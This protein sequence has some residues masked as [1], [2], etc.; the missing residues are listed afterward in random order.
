MKTD[1]FSNAW[2]VNTLNPCLVQGS[3]ERKQAVKERIIKSKGNGKSTR[4]Y[5]CRI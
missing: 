5:F 2:K 1:K 3:E 4:K